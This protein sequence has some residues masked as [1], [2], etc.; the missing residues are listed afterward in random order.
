V[1]LSPRRNIRYKVTTDESSQSKDVTVCRN[2]ARAGS[3]VRE[4]AAQLGRAADGDDA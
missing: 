4:T 1:E 3:L 2:I